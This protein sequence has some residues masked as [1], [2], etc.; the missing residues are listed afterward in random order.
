[1]FL[2]EVETRSFEAEREEP[3]LVPISDGINDPGTKT[4][5]T[6]SVRKGNMKIVS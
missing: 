1:L 4:S 6:I 5:L 3:Y 2:P